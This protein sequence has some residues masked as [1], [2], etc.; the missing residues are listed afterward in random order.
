MKQ[1]IKV[2]YIS[3][4]TILAIGCQD[5]FRTK[6]MDFGLRQR[7]EHTGDKRV[8]MRNVCNGDLCRRNIAYYRKWRIH[9]AQVICRYEFKR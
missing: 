2:F 8:Y 1:F 3:A 9:L 6:T 7:N 5:S 4:F